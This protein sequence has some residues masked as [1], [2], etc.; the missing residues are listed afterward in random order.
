MHRYQKNWQVDR[1]RSLILERGHRDT[2]SLHGDN[3]HTRGWT[4]RLT[5]VQNINFPI[6]NSYKYETFV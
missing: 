6:M 1:H 3:R 2:L 4:R 5:L